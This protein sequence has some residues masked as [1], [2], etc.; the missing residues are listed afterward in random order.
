RSRF[1]RFMSRNTR[2]SRITRPSVTASEPTADPS[3]LPI[4]SLLAQSAGPP[5]VVPRLHEYALAATGGSC[6]LLFE[7]N[8]RNAVLQ[9]TSGYGLEELSTEPWVPSDAE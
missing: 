1:F 6:A 5:D 8:P 2:T 9:A 7:Q 4:V 3:P